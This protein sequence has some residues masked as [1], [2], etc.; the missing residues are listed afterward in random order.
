M[1]RREFASNPRKLLIAGLWTLV[2][3]LL[4]WLYPAHTAQIPLDLR[5]ALG[6][7]LIGIS[8]VFNIRSSYLSGRSR[9][10]S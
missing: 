5:H 10:R 7:F 6:G 2:F 1:T 9:R 3:G 8:G 4:L